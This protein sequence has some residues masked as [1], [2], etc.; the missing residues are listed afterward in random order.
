MTRSDRVEALRIAAANSCRELGKLD[1]PNRYIRRALTLLEGALANDDATEK[2]EAAEPPADPDDV[3]RHLLRKIV[4]LELALGI[5][6]ELTDGGPDTAARLAARMAGR[7]R[8]DPV[9]YS[10]MIDAIAELGSLD[11]VSTYEETGVVSLTDWAK[12][13]A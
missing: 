11:I 7:R 10:W 12:A 8:S 9:S 13:A 3:H 5:V 1:H 6:A 2:R 4:N